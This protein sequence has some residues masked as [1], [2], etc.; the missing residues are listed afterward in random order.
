[1]LLFLEMVM[2]FQTSDVELNST[3]VIRKGTDFEAFKIKA[4]DDAILRL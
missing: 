2:D 3:R 1:M 4:S